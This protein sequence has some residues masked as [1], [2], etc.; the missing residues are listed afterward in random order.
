[1]G[2]DLISLSARNGGGVEAGIFDIRFC[3][4]E[5]VADGLRILRGEQH[6]HYLTAILVMLKNFL[7][8]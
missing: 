6:P 1:M 7:T 5:C 3:A 4:T 2:A 8:D